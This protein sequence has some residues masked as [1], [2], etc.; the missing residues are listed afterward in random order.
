MEANEPGKD[1]ENRG[2]RGFHGFSISLDGK[3]A[4]HGIHRI[5]GK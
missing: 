2:L 1:S 5:H 3:M 4:N